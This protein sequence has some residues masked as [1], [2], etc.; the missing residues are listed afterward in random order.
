ML[1]TKNLSSSLT[2]QTKHLHYF[3][4]HR[5]LPVEPNHSKC[6]TKTY[7]PV[8]ITREILPSK[9]H[10]RNICLC[11]HRDILL[12]QI[13]AKYTKYSTNHCIDIEVCRKVTRHTV[14]YNL[15]WELQAAKD[16]WVPC[17]HTTGCNDVDSRSQQHD[18]VMNWRVCQI[19]PNCTVHIT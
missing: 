4:S 5:L 8:T 18:K 19:T 13:K 16:H 3:L 10:T 12:C 1:S 11:I 9:N 14:H 7:S 2:S 17:W 15:P 6:V